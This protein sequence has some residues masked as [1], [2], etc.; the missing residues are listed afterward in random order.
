MTLINSKMLEC[1]ERTKNSFG[2]VRKS[3][4]YSVNELLLS[5][6]LIYKIKSFNDNIYFK[7]KLQ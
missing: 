3:G 2:I 4:K 5:S 1:T 6:A 7:D